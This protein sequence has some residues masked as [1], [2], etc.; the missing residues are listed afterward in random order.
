MIKL[1]MAMGSAVVLEDQE[2]LRRQKENRKYLLELEVENLLL[3]YLL[4]AALY[5]NSETPKGIHGGWESPTC[6]LRGH[7]L[8]HWLSAAAI[9]YHA[10]G[11]GLLKA[12]ADEIV[13]MLGKCQEE[14]GGQ[15]VASIPE[16][17]VHWI[18]K[19]KSIWAPQYIIHKTFMGLLDM[20]ALAG[21]EKALKIAE[22][23]G[24]WF[25]EWSGKFTK[26][27]F[28]EIL[29]CETGGM[30]EIW[31]LLFKYTQN[32]HFSELINRYYRVSLFDGLLEGKD[33]LTNMHANTTIPE[34]MGA[35]T[36]YDVSGEAKWLE[37]V[38][39]YWKS[40][41]EDRGYYATGG[42]TSGEVWSPPME[43]ATRLGDKNQEH[44]TVYNMMRVAEFLFRHTGDV[45]YLDYYERNLY[46]GIMAQGYWEGFFTHGQK[47]EYPTK[48]LLT[49]FLPLR[50]GGQKGWATK[51]NDFFCCHGSL[52]QANAIFNRGLYYT[53][54]DNL[55]VGQFFDSTY[56][57]EMK[58]TKFTVHQRIDTLTGIENCP[59]EVMTGQKINPTAAKYPNNPRKLVTNLYVKGETKTTFT[60]SIRIPWWVEGEPVVTVNGEP[61]SLQKEKDGFLA[62]KGEWLDDVIRVEYAKRLYVEYLPGSEDLAAFMDGPVVL[63]GLVDREKTLYVPTEHPEQILIH[64]NE[65]HWSLWQNTYKTA[66]QDEGIRFVPI[67]KIGYERYGVYFP[68]VA[69]NI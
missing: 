47:S 45:K 64:D 41:V 50:P 57:G 11:D 68:L 7:F 34:V 33:V 35:A 53:E 49:Y 23:F 21:N 59:G 42:Q 56:L 51:T 6:E 55:V 38:Q 10:I 5:K 9:Q 43:L 15:W 26:E 31:V 39:A 13:D 12:K 37:I 69:R 65:R 25:Y 20:Y 28:Q 17:Y 52:V 62:I 4:E 60:I 2:L 24:E 58:G 30:L 3:P 40:A 22:N 29:D 66:G 1:N 63:A 27:E 46:N 54:A 44:C 14:N 61:V 36:A 32:V 8:G 67:Y 16:K 18:A 19:K 48:G